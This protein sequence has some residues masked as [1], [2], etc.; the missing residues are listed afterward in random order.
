M[1]N[2]SFDMERKAEDSGLLSVHVS[3]HDFGYLRPVSR[4]VAMLKYP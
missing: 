1:I 4:F 2:I 3:V